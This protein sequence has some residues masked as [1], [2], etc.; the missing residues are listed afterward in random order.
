MAESLVLSLFLTLI[1]ELGYAL[2]WGI[3]KPDI[4][5]IVA[6]NVLTNPLVVL[7]HHHFAQMGYWTSTAVPEVA[8]VIV[9]TALLSIFG[10]DIKRPVLLAA[11]INVFSYFT[12]VL[13]QVLF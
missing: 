6:M 5:L 9:E 10:K 8:A 2:V 4:P 13:L 7:W 1:L 12:G 11:C 3:K